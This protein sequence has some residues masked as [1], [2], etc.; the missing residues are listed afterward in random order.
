MRITSIKLF[1]VGERKSKNEEGDSTSCGGPVP[2]GWLRDGRGK[3]TGG[4]CVCCGL[5]ALQK[6]GDVGMGAE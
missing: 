4:M 2:F 5:C 1:L 6:G 3:G